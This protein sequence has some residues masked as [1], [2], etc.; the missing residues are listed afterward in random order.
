M[1]FTP[2]VPSA[3]S[4]AKNSMRMRAKP[5]VLLKNRNRLPS[6][7]QLFPLKYENKRIEVKYRCSKDCVE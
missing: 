7:N 2:F 5:M 1:K 3:M 6:L 4:G